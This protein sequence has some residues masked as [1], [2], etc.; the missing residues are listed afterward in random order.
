ML[1]FLN[2]KMEEGCI[3][4]RRLKNDVYLQNQAKVDVI[5]LFNE[6]EG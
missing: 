2:S 1:S 5:Q 3:G 6:K 4:H